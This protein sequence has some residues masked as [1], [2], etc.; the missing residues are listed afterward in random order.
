MSPLA[1]FGAVKFW[2]E[3]MQTLVSKKGPPAKKNKDSV[4]H[5]PPSSNLCQSVKSAGFTAAHLSW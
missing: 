4:D 2:W 3:I 1:H 5:D